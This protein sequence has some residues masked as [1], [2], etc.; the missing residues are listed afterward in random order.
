MSYTCIGNNGLFFKIPGCGEVWQTDWNKCPI[1][2]G[3]LIPT[4]M[5]GPQHNITPKF[6]PLEV[7]K[8]QINSGLGYTTEE[9]E[10]IATALKQKI[11][12]SK[13][14]AINAAKEDNFERMK[15]HTDYITKLE[16]I[17]EKASNRPTMARGMYP[18]DDVN[19]SSGI[20]RNI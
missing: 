8:M 12:E 17:I 9:H 15:Q 20:D 6:K 19:S 1:C 16:T 13:E 5:V 4:S 7:N 2:R 11:Q 10:I 14:L 18:E 3:Y